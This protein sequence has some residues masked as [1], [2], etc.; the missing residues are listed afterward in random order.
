M[1]TWL[2]VLLYALPMSL[3]LS[4]RLPGVHSAQVAELIALTKA[5]QYAS[6]KSA[7]VYTDSCYAFGVVHDFGQLWQL[8]SF[9]TAQGTPIKNAPHVVDRLDVLHLPSRLAVVKCLAYQ[10]SSDKVAMGNSLADAMDKEALMVSPPPSSPLAYVSDAPP[11]LA[12]TAHLVEIQ[13]AVWTK[14]SCSPD[15]EGMWRHS[16]GQPVCPW[17]LLSYLVRQEGVTSAINKEWY[18]PGV[19][20]MAKHV[21]SSCITCQQHNVGHPVQVQTGSHPLPWGPF[22]HAQMVFIEMPKCCGYEYIL[23]LVCMYSGWIEAYPCA[24]ANTVTVAKDF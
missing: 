18:A 1:G 11:A 7:T 3:L 4:G 5:F 15:S 10:T 24:K 17:S 19:H 14:N 20:M 9:L 12:T 22:V 6:G 21:C 2:L 8:C 16:D 13:Q 23:V